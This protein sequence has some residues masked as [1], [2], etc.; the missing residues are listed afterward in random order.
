M[1]ALHGSCRYLGYV[2]FRKNTMERENTK[3]TNTAQPILVNIP[4]PPSKRALGKV[5][6]ENIIKNQ[7]EME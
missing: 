2:W 3:E 4:I 5:K 7:V 1:R 6:S